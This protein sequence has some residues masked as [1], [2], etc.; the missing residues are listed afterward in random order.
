MVI[1]TYFDKQNTIVNGSKLNVGLNPVTELFYDGNDYSRFLFHF[2][3]T[4]IKDFINDGTYPYTTN[5]KHRL[6]LTNC[7]SINDVDRMIEY[8][9]MERASS[10][11]LIIFSIPQPWDGG[12]GFDYKKDIWIKGKS[13]ISEEGSNW[14]N[15][16]TGVKWDNGGI[17]TREYIEQQYQN[18]LNG[19][20][21]IILNK[22]PFNIG[23]ENIDIDFT[24]VVNTLLES[25]EDINYG[26]CMCFA[27]CYEFLERKEKQYIGFFTNNTN[28]FFEPYLETTYTDIISDDR[29][30]FILNKVNRLYFY[31]NIGG[32]PTML[33]ELPTCTITGNYENGDEFTLTPE[34]K[35]GGKGVYYVEFILSSNNGDGLCISDNRMFHDKWS[36]IKFHNCNTDT[37]IT[38]NDV[39]LDFVTKPFDLYYNFGSGDFLPKQYKPTIIGI[40]YDE[41]I[42]RGNGEMRKC[43]AD[44]RI[45]YT[46][47]QSQL[48]DD[49]EYQI[50]VKMDNNRE[51]VVVDWQ[52]INK[53]F[54]NN[55]FLLDIDSFLPNNNYNIRIKTISNL[56]I[57]THDCLKFK[58]AN[59]LDEIYS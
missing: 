13:Y 53:G 10:F 11:D 17:Y 58:I 36:N 46:L 21:S 6:K 5:L 41:K 27:P 24:D 4:K 7:G 42:V 54:L 1:K 25:E 9:G 23:N 48:L 56:E 38:L 45:P 44:F 39:E 15:S 2:D 37:V 52:K 51:I 47:N 43:F 32:N 19:D 22:I 49:M 20:E 16:R 12:K 50:Y 3:L 55:Y 29:A 28:S 35:I 30:D 8:H 57:K 18:Y 59:R 33:S 40:N 34:V 26:F 14:F 31:S